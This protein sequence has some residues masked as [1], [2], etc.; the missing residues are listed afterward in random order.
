[1]TDTKKYLP[2]PIISYY[3]KMGLADSLLQTPI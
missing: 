2:I 3:A 1:M